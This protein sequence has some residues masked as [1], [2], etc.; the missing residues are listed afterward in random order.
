M[1]SHYLLDTVVGSVMMYIV[2]YVLVIFASIVLV[3]MVGTDAADAVTG[4]IASVGSVGPGVGELGS[5]DNYSAQLPLAKLIYTF[6]M[7]LGRLEIYPVLLVISM[8]FK[9]DR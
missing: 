8:I 6:D 9:R 1:D 3:M 2:V 5:L 4:V 7:F